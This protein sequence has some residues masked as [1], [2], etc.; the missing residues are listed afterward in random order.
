M[1]V[2]DAAESPIVIF[3]L[4][5]GIN[6]KIEVQL[7]LFFKGKFPAQITEIYSHTTYKFHI[8]MICIT[9]WDFCYV[10]DNPFPKNGGIL[11]KKRIAGTLVFMYNTIFPEVDNYK[12]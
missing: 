4:T 10:I 2:I 1:K 11:K 9:L 5:I 12:R 6:V 7:D 8:N 3:F